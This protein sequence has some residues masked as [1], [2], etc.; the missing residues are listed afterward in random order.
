MRKTITALVC[1]AVFTGA[2]PVAAEPPAQLLPFFPQAGTIGRDLFVTN[3]VDLDEGPGVRDYACGGQSYDGHTGIDSIVRS[4][5]EVQIGVPVF[6]ALDGRVLSVQQAVGGDFNWG[7][8][9]SNFDNHVIL[10]HGGDQQTVYGHL[11]AKSVS[12]KKGQWVVAGTQIGRTASSG[13]SSWPHL[14]FT[15][16]QSFAPYEPFAGRCAAGPGG[17]VR[18][19]EIP[20]DA[21]VGDIALSER[22]F[23]GRRDL[24]WD[25]AVRTGTFV[26]GLRDV[27]V[28]VEVRNLGAAGDGRLIV[29]RPDGSVAYAG[30]LDVAGYRSGWAKRKLRLRLVPGR[31]AL[32]YELGGT[33]AAEAPFDVVSARR[34]VVNRRPN[35]VTA[36]L[37]PAA[38]RAGEV[39]VCRVD[40]SLVTEDPDFDI[41]RYR[42]RWTSGGRVLRTVTSAALSDALRRD[43]AHPGETLA[44]EVTPSDGK[45]RGPPAVAS[46][47]LPE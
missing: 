43:A 35:P 18:Q 36:S 30:R 12:V 45:L 19:P 27:H 37:D 46:A 13:N 6:A 22:P 20:E 2:A 10:D 25:E 16:R 44:C 14:H 28:R 17:W 47:A 38:P 1:V 7:P 32:A 9:V 24:P 11:A 15:V 5:R 26:R 23:S 34:Q 42:Y 3:F 40:T 39:V 4:F 33:V 41:V 31:W 21:W 29:E 8:T